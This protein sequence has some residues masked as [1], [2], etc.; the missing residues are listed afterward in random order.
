MLS[1]YIVFVKYSLSDASVYESIA[2]HYVSL[3]PSVILAIRT[4]VE[5]SQRYG[6]R[7]GICGE[8]AGEPLYAVVLTGL[9]VIDLSVS[10]YL[11]PEIKTILRASTYEE[12]V[13]LAQSCMELSTP[14]E[15]RAVVTDF[16]CRR[17]PQYFS[18]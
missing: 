18:T 6:I 10:P 12:A 8:M 9:G 1:R 11:I 7:V 3:H 13:G 15:V 16:M 2:V 4:V 17:F 5:A 14:T